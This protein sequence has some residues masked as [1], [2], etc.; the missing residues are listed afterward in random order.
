MFASIKNVRTFAFPFSNTL[1]S[2][3]EKEDCPIV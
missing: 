2:A 1:E 3:A